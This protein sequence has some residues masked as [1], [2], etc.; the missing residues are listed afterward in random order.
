MA[1][2]EAKVDFAFRVNFWISMCDLGSSW[3]DQ[4]GVKTV[5]LNYRNHFRFEQRPYG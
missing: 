1:P 4:A 3:A 5:W 2:D